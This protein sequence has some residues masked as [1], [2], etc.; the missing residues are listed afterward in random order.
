MSPPSWTSLPS[1]SPSYPSGLF[2]SPRL[3]SLSH[4]ENSHWLSIFH[5]VMYVSMLFS[6]YI[7][8]SPSP[9]PAPCPY[10]C[11]REAYCY[12]LACAQFCLFATSW[13]TASQ[14]PLFMEFSRQEYWS[15]LPFPP[16]GF[17]PTQRSNPYLGAPVLA[18]RFFTTK[19]TGKPVEGWS[20]LLPVTWPLLAFCFKVRSGWI[21]PLLF[22]WP[23]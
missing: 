9:H 21:V 2:Q 14:A 12:R 17:F 8:P 22:Y 11:S 13:T 6:P 16:Q 1:P 15:G 18:G 7:P 5:M 4:T 19:P 20:Y 23:S 3:S 10:I